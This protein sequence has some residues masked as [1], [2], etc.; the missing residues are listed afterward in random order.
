MPEAGEMQRQALAEISASL[1]TL[2][3]RC[4]MV[5]YVDDNSCWENIPVNLYVFMT[6]FRC[7]IH[8][9]NT[10]G[11]QTGRRRGIRRGLPRSVQHGGPLPCVCS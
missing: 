7:F 4:Y 5:V 11:K 6:F 8:L 9:F 1:G 2:V 10:L 3:S